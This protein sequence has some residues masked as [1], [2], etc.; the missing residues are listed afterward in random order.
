MFL[1]SGMGVGGGHIITVK[2]FE[3]V[4]ARINFLIPKHTKRDDRLSLAS[5]H[6]LKPVAD[7]IWRKIFI[8]QDTGFIPWRLS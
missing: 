5:L 3:A 1:K 2:K 8:P 4:I 7:G 6:G